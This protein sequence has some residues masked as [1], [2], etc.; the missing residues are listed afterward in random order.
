[1]ANYLYNGVELPAL[2]EWDKAKYPYAVIGTFTTYGGDDG[3]TLLT[4]KRLWLL[5]EPYVLGS[6]FGALYYIKTPETLANPEAGTTYCYFNCLEENNYAVWE[7]FEEKEADGNGMT[8]NAPEW[9]NYD[10]YTTDGTL[11]LAASEPV[12]VT[13]DLD[14]TSWLSGYRLGCIA[15]EHLRG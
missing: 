8:I 3:F 9:S 2:P 5:K 4:N 1:M 15:R 14:P 10:V 13:P 11:Y 7:F 12:P 6:K